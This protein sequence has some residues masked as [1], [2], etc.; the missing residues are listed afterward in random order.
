MQLIVK[1]VENVAGLHGKQ[2][3]RPFWSVE[4]AR[5]PSAKYQLPSS[6]ND[7]FGEQR[8]SAPALQALLVLKHIKVVGLRRSAFT[9]W[10]PH[11]NEKL[12]LWGPSR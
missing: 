5:V 12:L 8:D 7:E 10:S 11:E 6:S 1:E 4:R 9:T 3:R 2:I